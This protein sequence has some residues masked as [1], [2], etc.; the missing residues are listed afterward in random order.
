M[1]VLTL[2]PDR[3]MLKGGKKSIISN[4]LNHAKRNSNRNRIEKVLHRGKAG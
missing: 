3:C 2:K 1:N 4:N